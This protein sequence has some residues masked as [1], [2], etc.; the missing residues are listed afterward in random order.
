MMRHVVSSTAWRVH[1]SWTW[2][3]YGFPYLTSVDNHG[4][5]RSPDSPHYLS[6]A[7]CLLARSKSST[8][9]TSR[10]SPWRRFA[11]NPILSTILSYRACGDGLAG[12]TCDSWRDTFRRRGH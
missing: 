1:L 8:T 10:K 5:H 7:A 12:I 9:K 11:S 6:L 4:I 3:D 2:L